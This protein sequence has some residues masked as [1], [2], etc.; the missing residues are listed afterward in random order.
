MDTRKVEKPLVNI[1]IK[2]SD[3]SK[4]K[5]AKVAHQS[6]L[7][8]CPAG[9]ASSAAK[10]QVTAAYGGVGKRSR[11]SLGLVG[12]LQRPSSCNTLQHSSVKSINKNWKLPTNKYNHPHVPVDQRKKFHH[13]LKKQEV[14]RSRSRSGRSGCREAGA[15][16]GSSLRNSVGAS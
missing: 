1:K 13:L 9:S 8:L 5:G 16:A 14:R 15:R 3:F 12:A 2:S 4:L 11:Q 7:R 10:Q 6:E